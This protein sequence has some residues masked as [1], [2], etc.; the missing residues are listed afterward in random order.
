MYDSLLKMDEIIKRIIGESE[1]PE[2]KIQKTASISFDGDQYL[3]RIPK[4]ISDY[5]ELKKKDKIKFIVDVTIVEETKKRYM[6]V[7]IVES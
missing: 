2:V 1:N 3:V 7:E 4:R 6:V 5:L